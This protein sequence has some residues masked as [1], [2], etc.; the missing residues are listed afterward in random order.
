MHKEYLV[1]AKNLEVRVVVRLIQA[2]LEL[3]SLCSIDT[4][5]KRSYLLSDL[6]RTEMAF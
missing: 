6:R 4:A 1:S 2:A 3:V 5:H